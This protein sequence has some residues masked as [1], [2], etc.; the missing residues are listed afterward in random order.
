MRCDDIG[1]RLSTAEADAQASSIRA[2]F[3]PEKKIGHVRRPLGS[4]APGGHRRGTARCR[5]AYAGCEARDSRLSKISHRS[6][7]RTEGSE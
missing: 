6:I 1:S 3:E 5:R 7:R 4:C 2:Q